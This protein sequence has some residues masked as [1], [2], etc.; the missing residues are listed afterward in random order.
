[1]SRLMRESIMI[2]RTVRRI[3]KQLEQLAERQVSM[4]RAF[5]ILSSKATSVE[6]VVVVEVMR[7]VY[8]EVYAG[9]LPIIDY[10]VSST[11]SARMPSMALSR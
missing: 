5:D 7:E 8:R 1:M 4:G 11:R 3:G 10:V 9:D 2:R 6:E